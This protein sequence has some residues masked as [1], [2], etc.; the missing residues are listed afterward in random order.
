MFEVTV[1]LQHFINETKKNSLID[2][3]LQEELLSTGLIAI[4]DTFPST[5][6]LFIQTDLVPECVLRLIQGE[7]GG[8]TYAEAKTILREGHD[9]GKIYYMKKMI[10]KHK[11][12]RRQ[13]DCMAGSKWA[14]FSLLPLLQKFHYFHLLFLFLAKDSNGMLR[15]W[16]CQMIFCQLGL[17]LPSPKSLH[18]VHEKFLV[19]SRQY[20]SG[21][22]TAMRNEA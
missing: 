17:M 19:L 22:S 1:T 9:F 14:D 3:P 15:C 11:N 13:Q 2:E 4:E 10:I 18:V 7:R 12:K 21:R 6:V 20:R 16:L 8:I 5:P